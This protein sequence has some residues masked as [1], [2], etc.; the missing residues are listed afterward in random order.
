MA[1]LP[2]PGGARAAS[3]NF[4]LPTTRNKSCRPR[5]GCGLHHSP[6]KFNNARSALP[7]PGGAR[8]APAKGY[9]PCQA[10][11]ADLHSLQNYCSRT[12]K[13]FQAFSTKRAGSESP[14]VRGQRCEPLL[15]APILGGGNGGSHWPRKP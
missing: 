1:K 5:E 9:N 12:A 10:F 2:S 13:E 15:P 7:S 14:G 8:A 6:Y 4:S 11:L 3:R